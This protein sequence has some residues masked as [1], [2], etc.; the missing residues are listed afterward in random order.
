M[1]SSSIT[2]KGQVT[3]PSGLR[4]KFQLQPGD[5]VLFVEKDGVITLVPMKQDITSLAGCLADDVGGRQASLDDME[6]AIRKGA[7]RGWSQDEASDDGRD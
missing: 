3:I 6:A 2:T 7:T 4:E 1:S 5:K